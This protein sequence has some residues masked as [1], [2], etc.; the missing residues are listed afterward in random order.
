MTTSKTIEQLIEAGMTVDDIERIDVLQNEPK[1]MTNLTSD[2]GRCPV[3]GRVHHFKT[4]SNKCSYCGQ[5]LIWRE[6]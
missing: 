5:T 1:E 6:I 2:S 4:K 3:C